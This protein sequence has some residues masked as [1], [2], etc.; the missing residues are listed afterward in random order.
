MPPLLALVLK[1]I[2]QKPGVPPYMERFCKKVF[3]TLPN[4]TKD[5]PSKTRLQTRPQTASET[6][7]FPH[8]GFLNCELN[9]NG[10]HLGGVK[11]NGSVT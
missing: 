6:K 9:F 5:F 3:D 11:H 10:S 2:P 8:D 7:R 4:R 1:L